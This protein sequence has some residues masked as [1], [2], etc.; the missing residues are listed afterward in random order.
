MCFIFFSTLLF[1]L[2]H[3]FCTSTGPFANCTKNNDEYSS[4]DKI[5][6]STMTIPIDY[7]QKDIISTSQKTFLINPHLKSTLQLK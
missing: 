3:G 5:T 4:E 2:I 6:S 1:F 7:T